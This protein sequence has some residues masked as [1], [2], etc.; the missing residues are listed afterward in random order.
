VLAAHDSSPPLRPA[1]RKRGE[2][3]ACL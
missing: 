1:M 2:G 3:T